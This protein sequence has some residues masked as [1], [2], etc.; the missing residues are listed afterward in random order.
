MQA[1]HICQINH[2]IS[3]IQHAHAEAVNIPPHHITTNNL[4]GSSMERIQPSDAEGKE[5]IGNF[6]NTRNSWTETDGVLMAL[7]LPG[8]YLQTD[9]QV[10]RVFDHVEAGI[11]LSNTDGIT[12][13]VSN[14]TSYDASVALFAETSAQAVKPLGAVNFLTWPKVGV[15]AGKTIK[16]LV[17]KNGKIKLL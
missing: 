11:A 2:L 6:I 8:I 10:L 12:L 16:V 5:A 4:P 13:T 7:E 14:K 3:D 15:K 9:K 1:V 17:Q